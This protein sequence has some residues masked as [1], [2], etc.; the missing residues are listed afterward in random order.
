[1]RGVNREG[2]AGK[3]PCVPPLAREAREEVSPQRELL[4]SARVAAIITGD[5]NFPTSRLFAAVRRSR[6]ARFRR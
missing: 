5:G 4:K 6:R 3:S 1:V 2:I